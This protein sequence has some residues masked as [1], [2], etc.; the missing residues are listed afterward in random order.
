ML[1]KIV[2]IAWI[3]FSIYEGK[4]E[5]WYFHEKYKSNKSTKDIHYYFTI[6]RISVGLVFLLSL[7]SIEFTWINLFNSLLAVIM[8]IAMFPFWHDGYYYLERNNL[9][10]SIYKKR[11][12]D[13]NDS[14]A[15]FDFTWNERKI[16]F[17]VSIIIM[18]YRTII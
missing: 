16:M 10:S 7:I 1:E 4:R 15:I 18:I 8:L 3:I 5:A 6:Q 17:M 9:N 13:F 14:S 11:F 2:L 12:K